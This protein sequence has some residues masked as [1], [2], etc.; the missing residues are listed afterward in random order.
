[1]GTGLEDGVSGRVMEYV[2][3]CGFVSLSS[4]SAADEMASIFTDSPVY[5]P[6]EEDCY[7]SGYSMCFDQPGQFRTFMNGVNRWNELNA[8]INDAANRFD[9]ADVVALVE[10]LENGEKLEAPP[11]PSNS[12]QQD[13]PLKGKY[14]QI[15]SGLSSSQ[16]R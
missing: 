15:L 5:C 9:G 6:S 16:E 3:Q 2:Y 10:K 11:P 1:M 7:C 4:R 12:D 13:K 8:Q 14:R